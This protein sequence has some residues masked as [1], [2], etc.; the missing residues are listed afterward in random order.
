MPGC[1]GSA[2]GRGFFGRS[3][4]CSFF[5]FPSAAFPILVDLIKYGE[6]LAF[7]SIGGRPPSIPDPECG[8]VNRIIFNQLEHARRACSSRPACS[9]EDDTCSVID[10]I[11]GLK[12]RITSDLTPD[13][14]GRPFERDI[15]EV[16]R[17]LGRQA[18]IVKD[19][20]KHL[21]L[22]GAFEFVR[23]TCVDERFGNRR[24][25]PVEH[26]FPLTP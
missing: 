18:L 6:S 15:C 3:P 23:F 12:R 8:P 21:F 1:G 10:L 25:T 26:D 13:Y 22:P 19:V 7:P 20:T 5:S 2:R 14:S 24:A 4:D 9:T 16:E 11:A 17:P